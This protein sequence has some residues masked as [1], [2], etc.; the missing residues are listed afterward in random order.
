[1]PRPSPIVCE[2]GRSP[3]GLNRLLALIKQAAH[4]LLS[5][6]LR[7]QLPLPHPVVRH[8]HA[9]AVRRQQAVA[10]QRTAVLPAV[11]QEMRWPVNL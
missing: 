10:Q 7:L 6:R 9:P 11:L 5:L 1:M 8:H 2:G 3:A 4:V